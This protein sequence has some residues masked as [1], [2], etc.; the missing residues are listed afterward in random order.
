MVKTRFALKRWD[1]EECLCSRNLMI[2]EVLLM[3]FL[4]LIGNC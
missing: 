2:G 1:L 3:P 4:A